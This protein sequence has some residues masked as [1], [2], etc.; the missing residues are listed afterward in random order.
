MLYFCDMIKKPVFMALQPQIYM[1]KPKSNTKLI[2][3]TSMF[4]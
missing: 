2:E 1:K 4:F 3:F